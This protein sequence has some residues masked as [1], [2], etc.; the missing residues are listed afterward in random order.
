MAKDGGGAIVN[1]DPRNP[2]EK[3]A[4]EGWRKSVP[5]TISWEKNVEAYYNFKAPL[6][7]VIY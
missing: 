3:C 2:L 4:M 7:F 1:T 6:K 5:A